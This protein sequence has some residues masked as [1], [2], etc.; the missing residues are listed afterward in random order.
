MAAMIH[1]AGGSFV[2]HEKGRQHFWKGSHL[3]SIKTF[4]GGQA[5]YDTGR[6]SYLVKDGSYLVLNDGQPYAITL[7]SR[8]AVE[9]FCLFFEPGLADDVRR[10]STDAPE[11]LLDDPG[12]RLTGTTFIERTYPLSGDI[13][14]RISDLKD[15]LAEAPRGQEQLQ[16]RLHGIL[17][18]LL[19]TQLALIPEMNRMKAVK[20]STR[21]ELYRRLHRARDF[22]AA[23]FQSTLRL[24]DIAGVACLSPNHFLRSF[25]QVFG[26]SPHQYLTRLR[27]EE[28]RQ[29]LEQS[30]LSVTEICLSVGFE[31]HGSFS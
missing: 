5:H 3:L 28:A 18:C 11:S 10:S 17:E 13:A 4:L 9:S 31:S 7:E 26:L 27:L 25:K 8:R 1:R 23:S 22:M 2:L 21:E 16:E 29:L 12:T 6:G 14:L 19:S 24:E 15:L 30:D 20:A